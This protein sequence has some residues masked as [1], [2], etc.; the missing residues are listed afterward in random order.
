MKFIL[1]ST[2]GINKYWKSRIDLK[3]EN[4]IYAHE[5]REMP[6]ICFEKIEELLLFLKHC[7]EFNE[8]CEL[9]INTSFSDLPLIEV[10]DDWR[11]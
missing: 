1:K 2:S 7:Q 5:E 3:M 11:E 6:V 10:Y 4:H 9:I 8:C